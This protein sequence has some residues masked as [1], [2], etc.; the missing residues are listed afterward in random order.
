[1]NGVSGTSTV[2]KVG[3]SFISVSGPNKQR[4]LSS[5]VY[6]DRYKIQD[7]EVCFPLKK[8]GWLYRRVPKFCWV[9][10]NFIVSVGMMELQ[11]R[12][13]CGVWGL[14]NYCIL[15]QFYFDPT[16]F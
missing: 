11:S 4:L 9:Q 12:E 3:Q 2:Q 8:G 1:M 5:T 7:V 10:S 15:M 14:I 13:S 6:S 16:Q